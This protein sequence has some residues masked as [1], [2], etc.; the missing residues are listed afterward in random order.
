MK[1]KELCYAACNFISHILRECLYESVDDCPVPDSYRCPPPF[2]YKVDFNDDNFIYVTCWRECLNCLTN[3]TKKKKNKGTVGY[4][5]EVVCI[6]GTLPATYHE[7]ILQLCDIGDIVTCNDW[8]QTQKELSMTFV[9][10][11]PLAEPMVSKLYIGGFRE[12]QQYVMEI[13]EDILDFRVGDGL[14]YTYHDRITNYP[15]GSTNGYSINQLQYVINE[16]RRNADSRRAVIDIRNVSADIS[17]SDSA[18]LQHM[19][20]LI[21]NGALHCKVLM[22]SNDAVEAAFMNAFAFVILQKS[23]AEELGVKVGSYTHRANSFHCY[24]KDFSRLRQ[25]AKAIRGKPVA[26]LTYR[27]DDFYQELMEESISEILNMIE[28]LKGGR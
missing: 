16:L 28:K 21:R 27:Y 17:S 1:Y 22:R 14:P 5:K 3:V 10:E 20:F 25:Y 7:S 2:D 18:C 8:T 13:I 6:K 4:M 11:T 15:S 19:Q 23:V 9:A 24:E 12:L 26:E